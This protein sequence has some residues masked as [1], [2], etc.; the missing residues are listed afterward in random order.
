MNTGKK[1]EIQGE[2]DVQ[3]FYETLAAIISQREKVTVTVKVTKEPEDQPEDRR[4]T[5]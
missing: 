5:A 3:R 4:E 1:L 2:F